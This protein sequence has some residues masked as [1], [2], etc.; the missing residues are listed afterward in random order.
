[1][2][3]VAE[4]GIMTQQ[5]Q[6][7]LVIDTMSGQIMGLLPSAIPLSLRRP[8][9]YPSRTILMPESYEHSYDSQAVVLL[10]ISLPPKTNL[11]SLSPQVQAAETARMSARSQSSVTSSDRQ[12]PKL[13][14]SIC[15]RLGRCATVV[16]TSPLRKLWRMR[17]VA[18]WVVGREVSPQDE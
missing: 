17:R 9:S 7:G 3:W 1:M 12:A 4:E 6:A 15:G 5:H 11:S 14:A 8:L 13:S 10:S 16:V 18:L 2:S